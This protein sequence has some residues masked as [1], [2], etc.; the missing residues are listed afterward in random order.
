MLLSRGAE[1]SY[2]TGMTLTEPAAANRDTNRATLA[3]VR[4]AAR[5]LRAFSRAGQ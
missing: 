3:S 2:G 5:V 1:H 4:N